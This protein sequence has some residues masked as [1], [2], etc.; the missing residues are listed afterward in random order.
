MGAFPVVDASVLQTLNL[1]LPSLSILKMD[2]SS[3]H[4]PKDTAEDVTVIRPI[5]T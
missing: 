2:I 1:L 3:S 4:M 5:F